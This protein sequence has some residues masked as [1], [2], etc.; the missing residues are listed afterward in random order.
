[1]IESIT[2]FHP[3]CQTSA[4]SSEKAS[5]DERQAMGTRDSG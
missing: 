4:G 3:K 2:T 5:F 1:M